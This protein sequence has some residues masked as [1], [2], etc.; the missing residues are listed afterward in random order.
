MPSDFDAEFAAFAAPDL[1]STFGETITR[2]PHGCGSGVAVSGVVVMRT[3]ATASS[4][5]VSL[6]QRV[7]TSHGREVYQSIVLSVPTA[8][9]C[10]SDDKWVVDGDEYQVSQCGLPDAGFTEV[11]AQLVNVQSQHESRAGVL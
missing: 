10:D 9:V 5:E 8:T 3:A 11:V 7:V 4:G 6:G 1:S 2:Y